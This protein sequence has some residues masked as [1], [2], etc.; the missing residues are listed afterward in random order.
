MSLRC[1]IS[2]V[3]HLDPVGYLDGDMQQDYKKNTLLYMA[4]R[5]IP[6][7]CDYV[8]DLSGVLRYSRTPYMARKRKLPALMSTQACRAKYT[9]ARSTLPESVSYIFMIYA[10]MPAPPSS[11]IPVAAARARSPPK[12]KLP[13]DQ[14]TKS[15]V[16][17][18]YNIYIYILIYICIQI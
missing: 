5:Y 2:W 17:K 14:L 9:H 12:K 3:L 18:L 1:C 15:I 10:C 7:T 13:H 4:C 6:C 8:L 16:G 11:Y